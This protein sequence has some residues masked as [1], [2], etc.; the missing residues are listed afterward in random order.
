M[1]NTNQYSPRPLLSIGAPPNRSRRMTRKSALLVM[2]LMLA[3]P[4]FVFAQADAA[5]DEATSPK[6]FGPYTVTQSIEV[7]GHVADVHGNN[8]VYD[9]FVNLH[10]GPRLLSQE[11]SMHAAPGQGGLFDTLYLSS[12]GFG[13]DPNDLARLRV[14][15]SKI[16][17]FVA[18]Y[19]RDQNYWDYNL[20]ANPLTANG[21]E[22]AATA[23]K[24]NPL[25]LPWYSNSPH[26][27]N[28]TRNMGDAMLTLFPT[29]KISVRLGYSQNNN[30]G[31]FGTTLESPI[32]FPLVE[33]AGWRS[34]RY[35]AGIDFKVLPKTTISIDQFYERDIVDTN[36]SPAA[37]LFTLGS[38]TGPGANIGLF[39]TFPPCTP[40]GGFL[41]APG[42][43][44]NSSSCT[45][46]LISPDGNPASSYFKR[47]TAKTNLPTTQLSLR[48]DY[49][50][51]LDLTADGSYSRASTA[52]PNF[53]EFIHTFAPNASVGDPNAKTI[54]KSA[55]L[56]LTY[57]ITRKLSFSDKFRWLDWND[58]GNADITTY[59]CSVT[60]G[61]TTPLTGTSLATLGN[62]CNSLVAGLLG[63]QLITGNRATAQAYSSSLTQLT[64]LGERSYFN[65]ATLN[66]Q[67]NRYFSGFVGFRYGRREE[68][69]GDAGI[70]SNIYFQNTLAFN[71]AA[72]G[73]ISTTPTS[74]SGIVTGTLDSDR[75]NQFSGLIGLVIRPTQNWRINANGELTSA[76]NTFV[77]LYPRH[78]Q[79]IR[80]NSTYKVAQW[81]SFNGSVNLNEKKNDF[82][83][84]FEGT[85]ANLFPSTVP[86][87]YGSKV[88]YRYYTLGFSATPVTK[89]TFDTNW[90]YMDQR[91]RSDTCMP[92][93][94]TSTFAG[95]AEPGCS[96]GATASF[97]MTLDYTERTNSVYA[98]VTYRPVKRVGVNF[99]YL[100][101]SDNG[102]T[103]WLRADNG[104]LLQVFGDI[105]GNAWPLSGGAA[106]N[107]ASATGCN[108]GP[109]VLYSGPNPNAPLGPQTSNWHAPF[110]GLEVG[111]AKSVS[112]KGNWSYYD[113]NDKGLPNV[114]GA[115]GGIGPVSS[116]KFHANV[117][118]LALKYSF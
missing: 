28:E 55:D 107:P 49:F 23:G 110:A 59:T 50:K 108:G 6:T 67:A 99:G 65:T 79:R 54:T 44:V 39:S 72:N 27:Q 113:Y 78:E 64:L 8:D 13:G 22:S 15:K 100:L 89:L 2:V 26:A 14:E 62:P 60:S 19:R 37:N 56:G 61:L 81:L 104:Q 90:T 53:M 16:Y 41:S 7:G 82:A 118:T 83:Q 112:F 11:L 71:T 101:T 76:D 86:A 91:M 95:G 43:L 31:S 58:S 114:V 9:T 3:L 117:G 88:H 84:N 103:N 17:N 97:P 98:S 10:S 48:S 111:L 47:G 63:G 109:C 4:L 87:A 25:A 52:V 94:A 57:H 80:I 105:Y 68:R 51:K 1:A 106:F 32:Q 24:L 116:Q 33:Q 69:S 92:L 21:L 96:Y 12:F 29:S 30:S 93:T 73:T 38:A 115:L 42:V 70:S 46:L 45:S 18:M 40:A 34:Y 102:R 5:G 66:Y 74:S 75:I 35:Q 77:N 36:Y 85:G 20:F